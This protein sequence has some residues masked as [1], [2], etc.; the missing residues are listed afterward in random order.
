[1]AIESPVYE[2]NDTLREAREVYFHHFGFENG[3]YDA[4]WVKLKAGPFAIYFP[5][6]QARVIAV[7][8]HDLHHIVTGY[9]ANWIGESE[10]GAWE[11]ASGC[12]HHWPA[13]ILNLDAMAIGLVLAPRKLYRAF[14]LGRLSHNL[15]GMPFDDRLL[16]STV[17][18]MRDQLRL[19]HPASARAGDMVAF[20]A[21]SA[22]G[23]AVALL[24]IL[25]VIAVIVAVVALVFG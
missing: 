4:K 22:L 7:K 18:S 16:S 5:N 10:I 14:V 23:V 25:S 21:W 11:V 17:G 1:M 8:Y 9:P 24:P 2:A 13:W 12:K 3:G 6:I 15:Y 20:L 19:N